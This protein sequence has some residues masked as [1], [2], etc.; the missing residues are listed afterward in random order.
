VI[1]VGI[2]AP[3]A[4]RAAGRGALALTTG[5]LALSVVPAARACEITMPSCTSANNRMSVAYINPLHIKDVALFE[6]FDASGEKPETLYLVECKSREAVQMQLPGDQS[7]VS[8][9]P[10]YDYLTDVV[11]S[12]GQVTLQQVRR[13]LVDLGFRA[14]RTRLP[15]GHCGCDLPKMRTLDCGDSGP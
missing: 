4:V 10:A 15:V 8:A 5:L 7:L 14:K 13:N 9:S 3:T 11:V 12:V 6:E 1:R 2:G